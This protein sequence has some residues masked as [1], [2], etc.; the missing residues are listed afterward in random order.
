MSPST[1]VRD[2]LFLLAALVAALL[3]L[4]LSG[5]AYWQGLAITLAIFIVLTVSLNLANGFTGV[6][7]LGQIGFMA[8]GAYISAILTLPQQAKSA[9]LPDLPGWLAG[10]SLDQMVGPLPVGWIAATLIA[11]FLVSGVAALVGAVLMRLSGPFVSVATL[12]FLVIVRV[13]LLNADSLTRGSRA[14][15]NVTR[16]TDLWWAFGTAVVTVYVVWRIK[17]SSYGRAMFAQRGDRWAANSVGVSVLTAPI[18]GVRHQRLLH[19]RGGVALRSLP[20]LVLTERLLLR[21]DL[22]GRDDAR[23]GRH[24]LGERLGHRRGRHARVGRGPA[25]L[26]GPHA[27][28]RHR[29]DHHRLDP[30]R[31]HRLP[32]GGHHGPARDLPGPP[33][34]ALRRRRGATGGDGG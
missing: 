3:A 5:L 29:R 7:T 32:A 27:A 14:F 8:L 17:R 19:G 4:E 6:F 10:I 13:V 18:A 34:R 2:G 25:P 24:G 15:S 33:L 22:P 21:Y 28:L 11:A 31:H 9:F 16:Y 20:G 1:R 26:R 30:H 23:R 12:G